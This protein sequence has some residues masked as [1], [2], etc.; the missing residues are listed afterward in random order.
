MGRSGCRNYS[1]SSF[2]NLAISFLVPTLSKAMVKSTSSPMGVASITIPFPKALCFTQS[3]AEKS[4][5]PAGALLNLYP[6]PLLP[7]LF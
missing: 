3:P 6:K 4:V 7:S 2:A 5:L 1:L